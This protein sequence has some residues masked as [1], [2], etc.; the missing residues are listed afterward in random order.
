VM[1]LGTRTAHAEKAKS[2]PTKSQMASAG[3]V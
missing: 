1:T 3:K 2:G